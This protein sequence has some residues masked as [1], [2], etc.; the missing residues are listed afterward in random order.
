MLTPRFLFGAGVEIGAFGSPI[1]GIRPVYVDRF[2]EY[3]G[4]RTL[5]DYYGDACDLP[6]HDSSL[7]YVATSHVLEHVASPLHAVLEWYRVLRDGGIIYMVIPDRRLTFDHARTLTPVA[8]LRSD[9]RA[10]TTASDS[11][12]I[13][14]F[15]F[16]IDWSMFS[17]ATPANEQPSAR[18]EL[19]GKYHGAVRAGHEI[20][21]HFHT[22]ELSSVIELIDLGNRQQ[23]WPGKISVEETRYAFPASRPDGVLFVARVR[24]SL[25]ERARAR[26][27]AHGLRPDARK[28]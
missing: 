6:F 27:A 19:A 12:H 25:L 23:V 28:L 15:V 16:G 22:F 24:K 4:Q 2:A 13:D 20:N 17:P 7:D 5:A 8:H 26:F 14:D 18:T 11:A 3:A 10:K 1:P 21:I 9:Y